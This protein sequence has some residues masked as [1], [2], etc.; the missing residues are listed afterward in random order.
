MG[1]TQAQEAL[2][3]SEGHK[4]RH[5]KLKEIKRYKL[6]GPQ[7]K[8]D[9]GYTLFFCSSEGISKLNKLIKE[10]TFAEDP[11]LN[12]LK[13]S[14]FILKEISEK[15]YFISTGKDQIEDFLKNEYKWHVVLRNSALIYNKLER[16][17][18]VSPKKNIGKAKGIFSKELFT[19]AN[20]NKMFK[21]G[22]YS[23]NLSSLVDFLFDIYDYKIT[24]KE[25]VSVF[26][27][28]R[29]PINEDL[30]D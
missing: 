22:K 3:R 7:D 26:I 27:G 8:A 11:I 18:T 2:A 16:L 10:K 5:S 28:F 30:S 15:E 14:P 12:S 13:D 21:E 20:F 25:K 6:M 17:I 1:L 23:H 9:G 24:E 29:Y 19:A 4:T